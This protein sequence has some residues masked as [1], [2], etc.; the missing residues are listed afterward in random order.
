[1]NQ[2]A[3]LNSKPKTYLNQ[4]KY[5]IKILKNLN[6]VKLNLVHYWNTILLGLLSFR[7]CQ[8]NITE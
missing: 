5:F 1:M 4:H 7:N 2:Y 6:T 8:T 3:K